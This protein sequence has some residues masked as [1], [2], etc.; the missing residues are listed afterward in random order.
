[1]PEAHLVYLDEVFKASSA[2]LNTL[3]RILNERVFENGDGALLKVPLLMCVAASNEWPN[4]Q[5]GGKELLAVFD[6]F[7]FRKTVRPILSQAGRQRLL[8]HRDHTPRLSTSIT[9]E[10]IQQARREALS[11]PWSEEGKQ[12]LETILRELLKEGIQPGDRRQF[13]AVSAAQAFAYLNGAEQ[14]EPEHLEV[15]ASVLWD[16]PQEQPEKC[17]A[18]IGKVANPVGMRVNGMLLEC[19]QIVAATEVKNL[20]QAATAA[21]KLGEIEKALAGLR[22]DRRVERARVYVREVIRKI[23]L[24]SLDAV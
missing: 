22:S 8:W 20:A 13:K 21:A 1:M 24:A 12:A 10:E 14:V 2:I 23:K 11:L 5:E 15:L 9:P 4:S 18:V 19:E 3:L 7:L 16:D 6:R 17:A